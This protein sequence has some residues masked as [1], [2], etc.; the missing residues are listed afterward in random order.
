LHK[1]TPWMCEEGRGRILITGPIAGYSP[2]P[3]L[4]VYNGTKAFLDNFS[5]GLRRE[6]AGTGV[7]VTCLMPG[8]TDTEI[9]KKA[10]MMDTPMGQT[11]HKDNALDVALTGYPAAMAGRGSVVYGFKNKLQVLAGSILPQSWTAEAHRA[12]AQPR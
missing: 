4:A 6:I 7:T 1:F 2:G 9:F 12:M 5:Y 10:K 3:Y 8:V 11:K